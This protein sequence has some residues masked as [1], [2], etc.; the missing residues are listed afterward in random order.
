MNT[1]SLVLLGCAFALG[2]VLSWLYHDSSTDPGQIESVDPVVQPQQAP[3]E[4]LSVLPSSAVHESA[5]S[6]PPVPTVSLLDVTRERLRRGE[7]E[8]VMASYPDVQSQ[9][10]DNDAAR[11]RRII[12]DHARS[13]IGSGLSADARFL[14]QL[15]LGYEYRD[16]PALLLLAEIHQAAGNDLAA[17]EILFQAKS[18]AYLSN[19]IEQVDQAIR[20]A[21][22]AY[23]SELLTRNDYI[24][25]LDLYRRL[26][27]LE[28]EYS[29]HFIGL[30]E[31]YLVLGNAVDARRTLA[32][33]QH[34][35][36]VLAQA[37][38]I[39][40]RIDANLAMAR[41]YSA[42]ISL[43][44]MGNQYLVGAVLNNAHNA[45]LLLDTGASLSIISAAKLQSLGIPYQ[46]SGK[47]AWFS[48]AG[49]R[50]QAPI[51]TLQSL[52]LDDMVVENIEVGVISE[53]DG[54]PFD[55]L[56]GMNYLRHFE[57]FIDQNE[58]TLQLSPH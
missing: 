35:S 31:T 2:W 20:S 57:F 30:A 50:V 1:R 4:T 18:Y 19:S 16:V 49:G 23:D 58:R 45:S 15:Y 21:V 44:P 52:A 37:R 42:G 9:L 25:R 24:A 3:V 27:E 29:L 17:I 26:T 8:V 32:L 53:L 54:A 38:D 10:P 22:R 43:Q 5:E 12:V 13:L 41:H 56:L 55:G 40:R 48:T 46:S 14:L 28:P 51:V 33:T 34:D 36:S 11:H 47:S 6:N 7:F 39:E